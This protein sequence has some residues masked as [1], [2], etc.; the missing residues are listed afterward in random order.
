MRNFRS[1]TRRRPRPRIRSRGG[2][3]P[4]RTYETYGTYVLCLIGPI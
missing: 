3:S 4:D 1:R 2:L